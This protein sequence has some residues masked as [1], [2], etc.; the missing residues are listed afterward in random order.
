MNE[1]D[2]RNTKPVDYGAGNETLGFERILAVAP[3]EA[4]PRLAWRKDGFL[5]AAAYTGLDI[6]VPT[7]PKWTDTEIHALMSKNPILKEGLAL[8]WFGHLNALREAATH[9]TS[10]I[11]EDDTDWDVEIRSQMPRIA[12]AVKSLTGYTADSAEGESALPP[13]GADWDVLWLGHC[14]DN[15]VFDPPPIQFNDSTVPPYV[16]SWEKTISPDPRHTRWVHWA[17]GPICTYAYAVTDTSARKILDRDDHGSE[18]FDIWLHIRCK[19]KELRCV[20]VSPKLFHHHEAAGEKDSLINGKTEEETIKA[21]MTDNIWHSAR[22]NSVAKSE[23]LVT[24]M[25]P[26]PKAS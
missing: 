13:Y 2:T 14:G 12:E 20:T 15:I 17:T 4:P 22:C 23:S 10:L 1:E 5:K 24:C 19:G 8:S 6:Q 7:Q 16:N 26:K 11:L 18:S 3:V 25:G 21:E 9:T